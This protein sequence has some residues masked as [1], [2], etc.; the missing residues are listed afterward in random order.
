MIIP[1]KKVTLLCLASER[2]AALDQLRRLGLM[3][4]VQDKTPETDNVTALARDVANAEKAINI[5][6]MAE[7][8]K[9]NHPAHTFNANGSKVVTRTLELGEMRAETEL[10]K[11]F[12]CK[13]LSL[14]AEIHDNMIFHK[15]FHPRNLLWRNSGNGM[16][17]FWIDVARCR[18]VKSW[19]MKRAILVDIHTFFRDMRPPESELRECVAYYLAQRRNG[20]YPGGADALIQ[21]VFGFRRR[22]FSKK[23]Y[24][25]CE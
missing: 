3:Q 14:L 10:R 18:R 21:D 4:V 23:R 19:A 1:M 8:G 22:L 12:T 7:A 20:T 25:V 2:V 16:E 17:I 13:H 6:R 11:E 5:I 15:A 24:I 9:N